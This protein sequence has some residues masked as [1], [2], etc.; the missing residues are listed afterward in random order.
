MCDPRNEIAD[1]NG[2]CRP[3]RLGGEYCTEGD[4]CIGQM[5]CEN[6]VC[7]CTRGKMTSDRRFC[8][9]ERDRLLGE[10][11]NMYDTCLQRGTSS[12]VAHD[13]E[14]SPQGF[15]RCVE[16]YKQDNGI[17]RRWNIGESGCTKVHHCQGG[18]L[19][20]DGTCKCPHGYKPVGGNSQCA[21]IG[22][23]FDLGIGEYCDEIDE[24]RY[25]GYGLVCQRCGGEDANKCVR[26]LEA[27]VGAQTCNL[28]HRHQ[29]SL[30][31][32]F[33]STITVVLYTVASR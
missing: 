31:L 3:L 15:C 22:A 30:L 19:C 21:R 10:A 8:Q 26:Y 20:L 6:N 5:S 14:C 16:G 7:S 11:C 13:A 29:W 4:V 12:Y 32:T 17:C 28:A 18:A 27:K 24:S 25:C 9:K 23:M 33:L 2:H 1:E